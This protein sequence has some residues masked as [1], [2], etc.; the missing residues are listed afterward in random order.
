MLGV[1]YKTIWHHELAYLKDGQ[2]DEIPDEQTKAEAAAA[3]AAMYTL[4]SSTLLQIPQA[5][6]E[7]FAGAIKGIRMTA[8][9]G[10]IRDMRRALQLREEE[11]EDEKTDNTIETCPKCGGEMLHLIRKWNSD[12]GCYEIIGGDI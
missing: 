6:L 11:I 10:I 8:Y 4:A 7:Q 2:A 9:G 3:E 12:S 1:D 5:E